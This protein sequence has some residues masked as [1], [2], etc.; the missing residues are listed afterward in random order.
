M[1]QLDALLVAVGLLAI[2]LGLVSRVL[3]EV[4]MSEPIVAVA[5]GVAIGP[6]GLGFVELR[7][8]GDDLLILEQAAR[9][10]L[11]LGLMAVALRLPFDDLVASRRTI[12]GL[13]ALIMPLMWLASALLAWWIIGLPLAVAALVGAV[14]TPT[15][16]IVATTI[17]TGRFV[18]RRVPSRIRRAILAE[19]GFNDGLTVPFVMTS[20]LVLGALPGSDLPFAVLVVGWAVV[21]AVVVGIGAGYAA[22]RLL[23]WAE[24]RDMIE[25]P[26]FLA[27]T[28][29]LS[30]GVLGSAELIGAE[31]ILAVFIAGLAFDRVVSNRDRVAEERVQEAIGQFFILPVFVLFGVALPWREWIGLGWSGL[32]LAVAVLLVRRLPALVAV[33]TVLP[34]LRHRHD[35]LF[36]GWF[37]P[38]GVAAIYYATIAAQRGF[39]QLWPIA[40]LVIAA[41]I[42]VHGVTADPF[43]RL[44]A[45][46]EGRRRAGVRRQSDAT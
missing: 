16:P 33:S 8:W 18:E 17:V 41:S 34:D 35:A 44:Y 12:A 5:L 26:S 31:G 46:A 39:E 22:G 30:L 40:A 1:H 32:L 21:G 13:V 38:I 45:A 37:G 27:Y 25:R 7:A 6:A 4:P 11:A 14:L 23:V 10:T 36:V 29:A 28:L 42:V 20:L 43:T 24:R 3:R 19:S 9:V 2:A 15:D